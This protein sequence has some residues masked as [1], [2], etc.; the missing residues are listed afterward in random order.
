MSKLTVNDNPFFYNV[1]TRN[2][3]VSDNTNTANITMNPGD[4]VE[5]MRGISNLKGTYYKPD[6]QDIANNRESLI[7]KL[8]R[9]NYR[10]LIGPIDCD[11]YGCFN[12]E[13][14]NLLML[15]VVYPYTGSRHINVAIDLDKF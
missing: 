14:Q 13:F 2:L 9:E 10:K 15:E 6:C 12:D 7:D 1:V 11:V 8:L 4:V 3:S 5:F